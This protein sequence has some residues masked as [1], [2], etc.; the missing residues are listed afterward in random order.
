MPH[1]PPPL[2][3]ALTWLKI[4]SFAKDHYIW[5]NYFVKLSQFSTDSV[6]IGYFVCS[7]RKSDS[8]ICSAF[9]FHAQL[10]PFASKG[11]CPFGE[12]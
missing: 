2:N 3:A 12:E 7:G 6:Y 9:L 5:L 4:C 10:C 1:L 8:D 11:M